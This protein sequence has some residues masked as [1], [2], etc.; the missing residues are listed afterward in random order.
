LFINGVIRPDKEEQ[1]VYGGGFGDVYR[2]LYN[3]KVVALKRMRIFQR[4][5]GMAR[6][7]R[8]SLALFDIAMNPT[9]LP[10]IHPCL[11]LYPYDRDFVE[12]LWF[13]N[14]WTIPSLYRSWA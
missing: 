1:A 12:K 3:G 7:R 6:A 13:G 9:S 10:F 5:S 8:V 11:L 14:N 4:H 2:A